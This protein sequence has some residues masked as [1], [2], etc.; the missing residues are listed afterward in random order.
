MKKL[1]SMEI[2][3]SLN[4]FPENIVR[5]LMEIMSTESYMAKMAARKTL[6]NMGNSII[7]KIHKLLYTNN[8]PLRMEVS[9]IVELIGSRKSIPELI[10]L[11]EDPE[12]D[13]RWIAAE[14]LIKIGRRSIVPLLKTIHEGQNSLHIGEGAHHVLQSLLTEKE[15]IALTTLMQS[16]DNYHELGETSPTQASIALKMKFR[17]RN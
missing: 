10:R 16:L 17:L 13:I 6:V 12:F 4:E 7:P 8:L 3:P 1:N 5:S 9:K 2:E 14:G 11:L 15:K